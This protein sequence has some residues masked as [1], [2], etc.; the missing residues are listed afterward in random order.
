M[1]WNEH[2][3]PLIN[4]D[5]PSTSST[6]TNTN[7]QNQSI[8][9]TPKNQNTYAT[10]LKMSS[11]KLSIDFTSYKDIHISQYIKAVGEKI[12][13]NKIT[14]ASK[15]SREHACIVLSNE[16]TVKDVLKARKMLQTSKRLILSQVF[17]NISNECLKEA[18]NFLNIKTTSE[19]ESL[20]LPLNDDENNEYNTQFP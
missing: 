4:K 11:K 8:I 15:I 16:G 17:S 2:F 13:P 1:F 14:H 6:Q 12:G 20:K 3:P 5:T 9:F 7:N 18:L 19:I 10:K